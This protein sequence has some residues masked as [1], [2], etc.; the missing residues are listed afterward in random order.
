M[1]F[2][3]WFKVI[4]KC[5]NGNVIVVF[6]VV[7][8]VVSMIYVDFWDYFV[9]DKV[10]VLLWV[11]IFEYWFVVFMNCYLVYVMYVRIVEEVLFDVLG[12]DENLFLFFMWFY[13]Y[14]YVIGWNG[15]G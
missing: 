8:L 3:D 14:Y 12:V 9:D 6:F 7:I 5:I 2:V 15:F 1:F 13:D 11:I 4:S 10:N